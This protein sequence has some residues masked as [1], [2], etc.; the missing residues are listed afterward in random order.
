VRAPA[1]RNCDDDRLNAT[2]PMPPSAVGDQEG[3]IVDP[4]EA[5]LRVDTDA[6]LGGFS[7]TRARTTALAGMFNKCCWSVDGAENLPALHLSQAGNLLAAQ[8]EFCAVTLLVREMPRTKTSTT[9]FPVNCEFFDHT[10]FNTKS[11]SKC[12]HEKL[13]GRNG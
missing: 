9:L 12:R 6:Y 5:L 4:T 10:L 7:R 11:K 2:M 13:V 1:F 3:L 8:L